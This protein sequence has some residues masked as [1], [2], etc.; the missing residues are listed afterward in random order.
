MAPLF[1]MDFELLPSLDAGQPH[2]GTWNLLDV[3][4]GALGLLGSA[5]GSNVGALEL[6][7]RGFGSLGTPW[8]SF[9]ELWNSLEELLQGT[10]S[11]VPPWL[12][13]QGLLIHGLSCGRAQPGLCRLVQ[14]QGVPVG[15]P[16]VGE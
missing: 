14:E 13:P 12:G 2:R 1:L 3:V 16:V 4:L 15:A 11:F 10:W 5:F 6:I 8:K 7:G 9:W